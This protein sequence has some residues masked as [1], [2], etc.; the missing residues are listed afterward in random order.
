MVAVGKI[1]VVITDDTDKSSLARMDVPEVREAFIDLRVAELRL[2][3]AKT[4]VAYCRE[5][6]QRGLAS[7]QLLARRRGD[8][9]RRRG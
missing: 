6:R 4:A 2:L 5:Q 9:D 3:A 8:T 7:M 1:D